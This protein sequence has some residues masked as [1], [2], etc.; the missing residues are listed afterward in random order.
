MSFSVT[1]PKT[2]VLLGSTGSIGTQTLELVKQF[3]DRFSVCGLVAGRNVS[4][5]QK[6]MEIFKPRWVSVATEEEAVVLK[7][8][9]SS[10]TARIGFYGVWKDMIKSPP[11][12]KPNW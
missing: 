3:S 4:L 2:I 5:L 1:A 8:A 10:D 7:T 6:Q 11:W 9:G 12:R